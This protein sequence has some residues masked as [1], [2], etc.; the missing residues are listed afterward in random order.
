MWSQLVKIILP[1]DN[2][3]SGNEYICECISKHMEPS[4]TVCSFLANI[5]HFPHP[6]DGGDVENNFLEFP[7]HLLESSDEKQI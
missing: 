2:F 6:T 3:H 5:D 4:I 7:K 1:L